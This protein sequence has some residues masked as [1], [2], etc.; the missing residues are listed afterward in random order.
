MLANGNSVMIVIFALYNVN[1]NGG[2]R[3]GRQWQLSVN[4]GT[5]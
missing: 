1:C 3:N 4:N 5:S 2:Y